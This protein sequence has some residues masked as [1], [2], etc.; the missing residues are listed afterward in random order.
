M[1]S[2]HE[3]PQDV[4]PPGVTERVI[5]IEV[6]AE[7]LEGL[8]KRAETALYGGHVLFSDETTG[9]NGSP[10]PPPTIYFAASILF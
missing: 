2:S 3:P 5:A 9:P 4:L 7:S 6:D 8:L 1:T 10:H